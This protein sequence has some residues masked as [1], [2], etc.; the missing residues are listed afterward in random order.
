MS[1]S[2]LKTSASSMKNIQYAIDT[3]AHNISNINT[4]AYKEK[5][6][7]FVSVV[8]RMGAMGNE[9]SGAAVTTIGSNFNQGNLKA[10]G[11]ATDL[12]LSGKG[13][14]TLQGTTGDVVY[15]RDG[16]FSLDADGALVDANG[17]YVLSTG[18]AR[19][20]MPN[21]AI[22]FEILSTGEIRIAVEGSTEPQSLTQLQLASF[23]N[24]QGL[25]QIGNNQYRE[26]L[27][28]GAAQFSS[29]EDS[30]TATAGTK[31][32]SGALEA[33]N[34]DLS[35]NMVDLIAYQR[36]YQS[37]SRATQTANDLLE[38]TLALGR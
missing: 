6:T 18:G 15:T 17:N 29:A 33:S 5:K 22:D 14:F 1:I 3:V 20:I 37:V 10:S 12:A 2:T 9:Y 21:E 26:T 28:S 8:N 13:F 25:E 31:I 4:T 32:V 38:T 34:A 35:T 27:N 30:G 24:P 23:T 36:S 19:I 11:L 7:Q 16:H